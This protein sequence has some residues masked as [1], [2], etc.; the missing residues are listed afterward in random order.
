MAIKTFLIPELERRFP[1]SGIRF[2][3]SSAPFAIFPCACSEIG[4]VEIW[5]DGNEATVVIRNITHG[6]FNCWHS[7]VSPDQIEKQISEDVAYFLSELV[8][9]RVLLWVANNTR[10]GG[11]AMLGDNPPVLNPNARNFLWPGPLPTTTVP[12]P[13]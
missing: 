2:L 3:P 10:S 4:E 11:W 7:P 13:P 9:D 1:D 6:H 5:D 8:A 12:S